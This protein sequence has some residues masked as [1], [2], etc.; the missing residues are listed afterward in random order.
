MIL[1][2]SWKKRGHDCMVEQ[3]VEHSAGKSI[4]PEKK[5]KIVSDDSNVDNS[6]KTPSIK[7]QSFPGATSG[8]SSIAGWEL[9]FSVPKQ[10][11]PS[12]ASSVSSCS[13]LKN[14]HKLYSVVLNPAEASEMEHSC[15]NTESANDSGDA[16]DG[17]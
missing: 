17:I 13:S 14:S 3:F 9:L 11:A 4:Y 2:R 8:T 7:R 6:F 15:N 16:D 12:W 5:G 1:D 10:H